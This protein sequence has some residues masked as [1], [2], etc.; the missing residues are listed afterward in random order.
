MLLGVD[1]MSKRRTTIKC[2]N[3]IVPGRV[4]AVFRR[5]IAHAKSEYDLDFLPLQQTLGCIITPHNEKLGLK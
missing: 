2:T 3:W 4:Q 5:R 1:W